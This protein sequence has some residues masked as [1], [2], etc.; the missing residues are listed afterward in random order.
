[1]ATETPRAQPKG[2]A[3]PCCFTETPKKTFK[4]YLWAPS[5]KKYVEG[6]GTQEKVECIFCSI[7][8]KEKGVIRKVLYMDK[9]VMIVLNP[10]PYT[11]GHI[12]IVPVRHVVKPSELPP[13]ERK[14]FFEIVSR[15]IELVDM[16]YK[17]DGVN[18]GLN[19]GD[20]AGGSIRHLHV[21]ILP[22]WSRGVGFMEATASTRVMSEDLASTMRR[23]KKN[24]HILEED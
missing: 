12:Q 19:I 21:H 8:K 4:H 1:M 24:L 11:V 15:A 14:H 3:N 2:G 13:N 23:Y 17:P 6:K 9:S 16:S 18:V 22:R 7:L 5:R 10:F 20:A